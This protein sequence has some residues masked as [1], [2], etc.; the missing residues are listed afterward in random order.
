MNE[1]LKK[2]S[3]VEEKFM[4]EMHL[5]QPGFTYSVYGPFT[6]NKEGIKKYKEKV[7]S[8]YIYQAA[9][10]VFIMKHLILLKIQNMMDI[11]MDLL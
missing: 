1:I 11:N 2:F 8:R 9:D 3:L 10:T 5:R 4:P 6:K 7:D